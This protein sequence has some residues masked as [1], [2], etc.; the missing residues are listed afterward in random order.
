[1]EKEKEEYLQA[2]IAYQEAKKE[3]DLIEF[4]LG[5]LREKTDRKKEIEAEL[6][7][8]YERREVD[9]LSG[10]ENH[11]L[12]Q[13]REKMARLQQIDRELEEATLH[14]ANVVVILDEIA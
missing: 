12:K 4:E 2:A 9:I 6:E 11:P 3:V 1:L 13:V 10:E 7:A 14:G 5:V 8:L